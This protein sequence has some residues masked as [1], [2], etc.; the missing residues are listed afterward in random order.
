MAGTERTQQ[1]A[2]V[3]Y[4]VPLAARR[5]TL[6]LSGLK[7]L[8]NLI[9]QAIRFSLPGQDITLPQLGR[10]TQ[11]E[12]TLL[13][14][15]LSKP[16][17]RQ[18]PL[19]LKDILLDL[20][21]ARNLFEKHYTSQIAYDLGLQDSAPDSPL[22]QEIVNHAFYFVRLTGLAVRNA[23]GTP[24]NNQRA[25]A[26]G[27]MVFDSSLPATFRLRI[28]A[29]LIS[30]SRRNQVLDA[31][32]SNKPV[33]TAQL[34]AVGVR[35]AF[36]IQLDLFSPAA[37]QPKQISEIKEVLGLSPSKNPYILCRNIGR[38]ASV[39]LTAGKS[40]G[41]Q[42]NAAPPS[43]T[44]T[45]ARLAATSLGQ[46][47]IYAT[48]QQAKDFSTFYRAASFVA[49]KMLELKNSLGAKQIQRLLQMI[50]RELIKQAK[51]QD[52]IIP[53]SQKITLAIKTFTDYLA[54]Q[55]N[56]TSQA[57]LNL[58]MRFV[59]LILIPKP[60]TTANPS[61]DET[62]EEIPETL[63]EIFR[64]AVTPA[65]EKEKPRAVLPNPS[66][67]ILTQ[68][69]QILISII[70]SFLQTIK[71]EKSS[72]VKEILDLIKQIDQAQN[73]GELAVVLARIANILK[74]TNNTFFNEVEADFQEMIP[75]LA[76]KSILH[77]LEIEHSVVLQAL[78]ANPLIWGAIKSA[79]EQNNIRAVTN[80]I[81]R[82][83]SKAR[84]NH[85]NLSKINDVKY[86][87]TLLPWEKVANE[88]VHN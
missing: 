17:R 79:I 71:A 24:Y 45:F 36:A 82:L 12:A 86:L 48:L 14:A 8:R 54:K 2:R 22:R 46:K 55:V 7:A 5:I 31:I 88:E 80:L 43:F 58:V 65:K 87:L 59:L 40:Q 56:Q 1:T 15:E 81:S 28:A 39:I 25:V 26:I 52:T 19:S 70:A 20:R 84:E 78:T 38:V 35:V 6:K 32:Q 10:V 49:V 3:R 61:A 67:E 44:R 57:I 73:R 4:R 47:I 16:T 62:Q 60:K 33:S 63:R 69:K 53:I 72:A 41:P 76:V 75:I 50:M 42:A 37:P 13:L 85:K 11:T 18:K 27:S 77:E 30:P 34:L 66:R 23:L 74:N 51:A 83:I 29:D 9:T 68:E 21:R 64:T